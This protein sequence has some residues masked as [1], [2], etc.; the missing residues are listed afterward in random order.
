MRKGKKTALEKEWLALEKKE[1]KYLKKRAER[2]NSALNRLLE[3]KVPDNL[4]EKLDAAFAKAFALVFDKGTAVIEKTYKKDK[5][6][7][8]YE[9][10]A[11]A[12]KVR[13]D[14][15]SLKS[16]GKNAGTSGRKNLLLSGVEG[17]GLGI[18]GIGLPDIPLFVGMILK[19][20][21]E[22]ALH[23]GFG[24]ESEEEK[25]F[26]LLLIRTSLSCEEELTEGQKEVECFLACPSLPKMYD[27]Q[28]EIRRTA[29]VLS[30]ELLY[31]KFLQGVPLVGA[32]G[33][34]YDVIY[35]KQI[36]TYGKI[37]Y[38]KRFL[39]N[40]GGGILTPYA[41]SENVNRET[42]K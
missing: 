33:G 20:M 24:Y 2:K 11:F 15:K 13:E 26:I 42:E 28:Q 40:C 32:V 4:S 25:Y 38:Q 10:D 3:A 14:R 17:V 18:L 27:R 36:L 21:Y 16:F 30:R 37:K 19:S 9:V 31:M 22:T 12:A 6:Q 1:Q 5:L 23:Y 39:M 34:A 8:T 29:A 7:K 35:L 41:G